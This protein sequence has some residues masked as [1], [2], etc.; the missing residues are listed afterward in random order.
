MNVVMAALHAGGASLRWTI[1]GAALVCSGFEGDPASFEALVDAANAIA[2]ER[3][4]ALLVTHVGSEDPHVDALRRA[5]FIDDGD[6]FDAVVT[7]VRDV[8]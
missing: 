1:E 6:A 2:V 7:L 5:G 8:R 4:L 3:F